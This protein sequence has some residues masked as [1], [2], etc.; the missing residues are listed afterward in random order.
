[1]TDPAKLIE[2]SEKLTSIFGCWPGFHD[3]EVVEFNLWRGGYEPGSGRRILPVLT[4]KIHLWQTTPDLDARG[5]CILRYHTLATLR[6]HDVDELDMSGFNQQNVIFGLGITSEEREGGLS[7]FLRVEFDP[8]FG[9]SA[10]LRCNR[11]EVLQ[12]EPFPQSDPAA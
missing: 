10:A 6:F 8:S 7:P 1:M 5:Y 11:I 9:I 3:A 4:V 2:S 12:V